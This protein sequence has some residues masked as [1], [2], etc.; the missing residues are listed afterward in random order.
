MKFKEIIKLVYNPN[1]KR[2]R[3]AKY[4]QDIDYRDLK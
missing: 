3:N 2:I 1:A 4:T